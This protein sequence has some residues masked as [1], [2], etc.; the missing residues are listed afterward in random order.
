MSAILSDTAHQEKHFEAYIVRQ[1]AAR[2]WSV[3]YTVG[4]DQNFA[5]FPEDLMEWMKATQPKKWERL[6]AGNGDKAMVTLMERL[7]QA[8]E[9]DGTIDV[10]RNGFKIAG[11]GEILLSESQPE[12]ERDPAA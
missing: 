4:Y 1:L 8:L 11:A 6:A 3:G 7:A 5:L 2:G 9:K 10:L 12:D